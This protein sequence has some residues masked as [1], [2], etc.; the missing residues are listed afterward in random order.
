MTARAWAAPQRRRARSRRGVAACANGAPERGIRSSSS[1]ASSTSC[2]FAQHLLFCRP[3]DTDAGQLY[4][5]F[6]ANQPTKFCSNSMTPS[7]SRAS[8]VGSLPF[9]ALLI[10][11]CLSIVSAM[12]DSTL[13]ERVQAKCQHWAAEG[14]CLPEQT[15]VDGHCWQLSKGACMLCH[16]G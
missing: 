15:A 8:V 11:Q 1:L 16:F 4:A 13:Q 12:D 7:T 2:S 5:V 9:T 6:A 10:A 14:G 3:P